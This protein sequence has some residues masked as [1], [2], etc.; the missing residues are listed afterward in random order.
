MARYRVVAAIDFGT[1]G[2]G[3]AWAFST[4]RDSDPR[5]RTIHFFDEWE[6]QPTSYIKNLSA[7]LF[8]SGGAVIEW[9][10]QA[11]RHY[12]TES[13]SDLG[14]Q[15]F[16][17]FKM[18]LLPEARPVDPGVAVIP[19]G[20]SPGALITS[21]LTCF[22]DF[23]RDHIISGSG[24]T[25]DEILWCITVPAIWRDRERQI[26]RECAVG[27]GLPNSADRLLIAVEP[28]VAALFCHYDSGLPGVGSPGDRFM[29]VD[30]GGG[31]VDITAYEV[32]DKGLTEIGYTSGGSN[33]SSYVNQDF[34]EQVVAGRVG[35]DALDRIL[36]DDPG[37][38]VALH[39]EWERVKRNFASTRGR[40]LVIPLAHRLYRLLTVDERKRLAGMQDGV[41]DEIVLAPAEA[42]RL[43]DR[44]IDPI[45]ALVDDQLKRIGRRSVDRILLVGGFAQSRYLQARLR[46][47]LGDRVPLLVPSKPAWAVLI[48]AVHFALEPS[49]IIG[50]RARF[51]YGVEIHQPFE[52]GDRFDYQIIRW[53]GVPMCSRRFDIFVSAG[54]VV[55]PG[56][57][58]SR[59]YTPIKHKQ[60]SMTLPLFTSTSKSPRYVTD[61]A[62]TTHVGEI[63]VEM[64]STLA[65]HPSEREIEVTMV[66]GGTEIDVRAKDLRTGSEWRATIDFAREE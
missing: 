53:D 20:Q 23:A 14:L 5:R 12:I 36:S 35:T 48:G 41:E 19:Q 47:H 50:R 17:R 30:A 31:T 52:E 66:F 16:H 56:Y 24:V 49:K 3:F 57:E 44:T 7:L 2:T 21:Y 33:G 15:F 59:T 62:S 64:Q 40:P 18:S 29:V 37:A 39:D 27:A 11:Q 22:F 46:D 60:D 32:T 9:G 26:M 45:L 13:R 54:E 55:E 10:Y 34:V 1:H 43:F 58:V 42:A 51:T 6:D 61:S 25:D 65:L 63:L 28:E 38:F 4:E 8:D